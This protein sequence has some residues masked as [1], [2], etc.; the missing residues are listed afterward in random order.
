[1]APCFSIDVGQNANVAL[2][3]ASDVLFR[4]RS[5]HPLIV[6]GFEDEARHSDYAA[7][8]AMLRCIDE[9]KISK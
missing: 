4:A 7:E 6:D 5:D 2:R 8:D 1:M 3:I 9:I